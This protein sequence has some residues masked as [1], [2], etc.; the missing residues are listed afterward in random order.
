[1]LKKA[2]R[3]IVIKEPKTRFIKKA[4]QW[5]V[6]YQ[7]DGKQK[8]KWFKEEKEAERFAKDQYEKI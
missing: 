7:E 3:N 8:Q 2:I 1:M 6:T 5:C 4:S